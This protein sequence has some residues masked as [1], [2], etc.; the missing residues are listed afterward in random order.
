MPTYYLAAPALFNKCYVKTP[1]P[2]RLAELIQPAGK[3]A[4]YELY[5]VKNE[6]QFWMPLIQNDSPGS[7]NFFLR[8]VFLK[9]LGTDVLWEMESPEPLDLPQ[10]LQE[11]QN[12]PGKVKSWFEGDKLYSSHEE[13]IRIHK[14][15][16]AFVHDLMLPI[17]YFFELLKDSGIPIP[18]SVSR[19]LEGLFLWG[20]TKNGVFF[21]MVGP[22]SSLEPH[23]SLPAKA[24]CDSLYMAIRQP[25][26]EN[27]A[28]L[29]EIQL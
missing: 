7:R 6:R 14:L 1:L 16:S 13:A 26:L 21:H 18:E 10:A 8:T 5:T 12:E 24:L 25:V 19:E 17:P 20:V 23:F 4:L 11:L 28:G 22:K 9:F 27:M 15:K 29:D 2:E 3:T